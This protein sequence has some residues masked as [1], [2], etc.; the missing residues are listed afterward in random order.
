MPKRFPLKT[1]LVH[2]R[3]PEIVQEHVLDRRVGPQVTVL[4]DR[5]DVVEHEATVEA[6]VVAKHTGQRDQRSVKMVGGHFF[7]RF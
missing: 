6:V 5:A 4:L 1:H 7:K 2:R 3:A